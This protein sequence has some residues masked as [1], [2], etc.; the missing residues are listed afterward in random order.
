MD[1]N[2]LLTFLQPFHSSCEFPSEGRLPPTLHM[3]PHHLHHPP[4]LG[5]NPV[6]NAGK[7]CPLSPIY[8]IPAPCHVLADVGLCVAR[9]PK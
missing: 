8:C 2:H 3:S 7:F 9:K 5:C 1:V 6:D 4:C